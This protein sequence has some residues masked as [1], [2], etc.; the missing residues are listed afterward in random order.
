MARL[1]LRAA[2]PDRMV[3]AAMTVVD[4]FTFAGELDMLECRLTQL[5]DVVDWFVVV[6]AAETFQGDPKPLSYDPARF[7]DWDDRIVYVVADLPPGGDAWV[8]EAA[9]RE[10]M[11]QGID[12]LD[13]DGDDTIIVSDVDEIWRADVPVTDLPRPFTVLTLTMYV[14]H[15]GWMHPDPW[16]GPVVT[17]VADLPP[18]ELG[19][20]QTVRSCR[21]HELPP[22][23]RNAGWHLSWFGGSEASVR[24]LGSFSHTELAD[25]DI[26]DCE[27]RGLHVDGSPLV[28]V[29]ALDVPRFAVNVEGW[30]PV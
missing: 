28:A 10:A 30:W 21:L 9:Q 16:H 12:Q 22:R 6:E 4:C 19:T 1:H 24:K 20:F 3:Q 25:V 26:Y 13:L 15:F 17:S 7:V 8:R 18:A 5:Q 29:S 11:W 23:V 27:S 14:H 2:L